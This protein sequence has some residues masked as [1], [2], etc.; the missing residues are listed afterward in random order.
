MEEVD[1][2]ATSR[3]TTLC[4]RVG[5]AAGPACQARPRRIVLLYLS[6][7][8]LPDRPLRCSRALTYPSSNPRR[9]KISPIVHIRCAL[10]L[11]PCGSLASPQSS[12]PHLK[13]VAA[14]AVPLYLVARLGM[15]FFHPVIS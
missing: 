14:I 10:E 13:L 9:S 12:S 5:S 7:S 1:V 15:I 3:H 6:S 4:V 2:F 8:F 11:P